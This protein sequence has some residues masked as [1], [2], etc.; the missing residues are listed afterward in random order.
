MPL[1]ITLR[2]HRQLP[3]RPC[4]RGLKRKPHN[5]LNPRL[6]EDGEFGA[7][8]RV[9]DFVV[10]G[11]IAVVVVCGAALAGVFA[12]AVLPHNN[13]IQYL[14]ILSALHER[15]L[16]ARENACGPDVDV[17]VQLFANGEDHLPQTNMIRY[18][19]PAHRSKEYGIVRS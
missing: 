5:P 3:P 16:R 12:F 19:R 2:N 4:L 17:L 15:A 7:N 13:P 6:G 8:R 1:R 14:I 10:G 9:A 18:S 11:W